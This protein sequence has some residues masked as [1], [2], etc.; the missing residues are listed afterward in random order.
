MLSMR[1]NNKNVVL[2]HVPAHELS[3]AFWQ[4]HKD[5]ASLFLWVEDE[6]GVPEVAAER[7]NRSVHRCM[8][9]WLLWQSCLLL[10]RVPGLLLVVEVSSQLQSLIQS[11]AVASE[12]EAVSARSRCALVRAGSKAQGWQ[13]LLCHWSASH[14]ASWR[15]DFARYRLWLS[16]QRESGAVTAF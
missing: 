11:V 9:Y 13:L 10:L 8:S 16:S 1:F 3:A 2:L 5:C 14:K 12:G 6:E 7:Q 15:T 4:L